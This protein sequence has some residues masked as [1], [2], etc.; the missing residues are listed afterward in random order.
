MEQETQR[1]GDRVTLLGGPRRLGWG[2]VGVV[3]KLEWG[4]KEH[5]LWSR[6]LEEIALESCSRT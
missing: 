2:W 4:N 5:P 6:S 1:S 3:S